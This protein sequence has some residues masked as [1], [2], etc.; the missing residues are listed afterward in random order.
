MG[1]AGQ[2]VMLTGDSRP[3]AERVAAEVGIDDV[4]AEVLPGGKDA[5]VAQLQQQHRKGRDGG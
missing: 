5:A 3:T 2:N 1:S 4:I